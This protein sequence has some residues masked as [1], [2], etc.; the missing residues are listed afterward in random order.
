MPDFALDI[1]AL[2]KIAALSAT[3][4]FLGDT[5]TQTATNKTINATN[6]TINDTSIAAGDILYSSGT[7]KFARLARGVL[8]RQVLAT[9]P[10]STNVA[11][12][13]SIAYARPSLWPSSGRRWGL[14]M[15]GAATTPANA[16]S[17]ILFGAA[18]TPNAY[19]SGVDASGGGTY[20]RQTGTASALFH[21]GFSWNAASINNFARRNYNP[22]V[23][24]KFRINDQANERF[25]LG[26]YSVTTN[27]TGDDP[28]SGASIFQFGK[29]A[30]A[31]S[32]WLIFHN[33]G[34]VQTTPTVD[35]G[36]VADNAIH[37]VELWG[38][39]TNAQ[40]LWSLDGSTPSA[41][42]TDI[43]ASATNMYLYVHVEC[44]DSLAKTL[45]TFWIEV[46]QN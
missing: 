36:T 4:N 23:C 1:A 13:T 10:L 42:T 40:Y 29:K 28:A 16:C 41:V 35:T 31:G 3:S 45:D 33:G 22:R 7:T 37:T 39:D 6:N 12:S 19:S 5:D 30:A 17:G 9:T 27:M 25:Y 8:P 14:V 21:T 18:T 15:S 32:N 46:E 24:A 38:D 44:T 20:I 11:A 43:P 2:R 26:W 34:T